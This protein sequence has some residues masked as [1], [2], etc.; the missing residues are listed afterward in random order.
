MVKGG[1]GEGRGASES[2]E[3]M[4][5]ERDGLLLEYHGEMVKGGMG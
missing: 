4:V 2:D 1:D 5:K 3:V